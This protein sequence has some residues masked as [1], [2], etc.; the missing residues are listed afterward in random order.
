MKPL[1]FRSNYASSEEGLSELKRLIYDVFAIDVS[2]L[3]RMGHDPSI[4]SF[5][6]WLDDELVANV[7]LYER[8]LWLAGEHVQAL[9]VQSVAVRPEFRGRGLFADLMRRA[10]SFA[11]ANV[12]L[13]ILATGTPSL[14]TPYGFR[15]VTETT[16][17]AGLAQR[18]R[19]RSRLLSLDQDTDVAFLRDIF[20]HR[21]P[22]SLVASA[23][24][25]P[26]SR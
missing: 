23:C 20:S 21:T 8:R 15:Q 9:G 24:D 26:R 17:G 19:P 25:H 22:T 14:Y 3:N 6:W 7:S 16:F 10:L 4:V 5:G 12:D 13:V 11:D 2:P 18:T 1:D